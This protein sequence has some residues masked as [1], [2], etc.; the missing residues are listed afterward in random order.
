[1]SDKHIRTLLEAPDSP[2]TMV[3]WQAIGEPDRHR[4]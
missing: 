1:V 4:I 3:P 2:W